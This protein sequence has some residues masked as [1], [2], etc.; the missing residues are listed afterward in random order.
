MAGGTRRTGL[1]LGLRLRH[2]RL[3]GAY[4]WQARER[5]K[6]ISSAIGLRDRIDTALSRGRCGLW[7]WDLA[8]GRLYWSSSMYEILG[9]DASRDYLSFGDVNALV[10]PEG[11]RSRRHRRN[12]RR[13][14]ANSIDHAFRIQ[15]GKGE[16][17]WLRARAE[18]VAE[19]AGRRR[20]SSASPSTSPIR[21]SSRSER[22][23]STCACATRSRPISEA[24]VLWD[25]E[26][27]LVM[28]NS[29]FQRLHNL[30]PDAVDGGT[31]YSVL[32]AKGTHPLIQSQTAL[33]IWPQT[34]VRTYRSASRRRPLA[35]DQRASHQGR[36]LR[37]GRH[38]HHGLEA[39][40]GAIARF[41]SAG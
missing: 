35:A 17:I 12:A 28:C 23:P 13:L 40:P 27:R 33:G 8:R 29:K 11:R 2:P 15:N 38:R 10:H 4:F 6:P 34:G 3:A 20:I 19:P 18:R 16:W 25:A 14:A 21:R 1:L 9:L 22:Q 36:R 5:G 30:P 41:A 24:F 39:Q 7:D 32:M 31:P 26:N 37:L